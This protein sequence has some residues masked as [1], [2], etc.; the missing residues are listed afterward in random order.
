MIYKINKPNE[1]IRIIGKNFFLRNKN[2]CKII[3]KNEEKNLMEFYESINDE[4]EIKIKIIINNKVVNY[5]YMFSGCNSLISLPDISNLD[6]NN[7]SNISNLFSECSS[8][9]LLDDISKWETDKIYDMSYLFS[10]CSSLKT[11]P[12]ISK[13]NTKNVQNMKFMFSFAS[14]LKNIPNIGNWNINNV[15]N[16]SNMFYGCSSLEQIPNITNWN[17]NNLINISYLFCKCSSLKSLP[18]ISYWNTNKI[19]NMSY[20]FYGCQSLESLPD[21]SKWNTE[22]VEDMSYMFYECS[23]IKNL[24]LITK[25]KTNNVIKLSYMFCGCSSLKS[26]PDISSWNTNKLIDIE[27]IF[28]DCSLLTSFPDISKWKNVKNIDLIFNEYKEKKEETKRKIF[29][30]ELNIFPQI[31][32]TFKSD[33]KIDQNL[34]FKIKEEIKKIIKE[35]NF[36]IIEIK[37]GS[38]IIILT[39][40]FLI[41]SELRKQGNEIDLSQ[42]FNEYVS[43]EVKNLTK[44]LSEHEFVSLGVK[45]RPDI[46]DNNIIDFQSEEKRKEIEAKITRLREEKERQTNNNYNSISEINIIEA[47]NK[48]ELDDIEKFFNDKA[49]EAE[50]QET[51]VKRIIDNLID[52][53]KLFDEEIEKAFQKSVFEYKIIHLLLLDRSDKVKITYLQE[54]NNCPNRVTRILFHGSNVGNIINILNSQIRD[55]GIHIYGKGS[56]FTDV[57]DYACLY[58]MRSEIGKSDIIPEVGHTYSILACE[59][60][61]DKSKLKEGYKYSSEDEVPKNGIKLGFAGYRTQIL[62]QDDLRDYNQFI[63]NEY[64]ITEKSQILPLY[65]IIVERVEYLVVW[66]DYNF[67]ENNPNNY[68]SYTFN[69]MQEFHR[70]IK[71]YVSS[72]L[73]SKIYYSKTTEEAIKLI[74]RKKYNKIV[75]ITN[76][77]NNGEDFINKAREIIGAN[78]IAACS[79]YAVGNHI[80]WVK[81][82]ENVLILNGIDFHKKFFECIKSNDKNLYNKLSKEIISYYSNISDFYLNESTENLFNYVNFKRKCKFEDLVFD[83]D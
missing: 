63:G 45:S 31:E 8:L 66:R 39:L 19:K 35:D 11:L 40:Q 6:L 58:T 49:L 38:I 59:I 78:T 14:L 83:K 74:K 4:K 80:G 33:N 69:K 73:N 2:N 46:V 9:E 55:A 28:N 77:N 16:I 82:M 21:I 25:W 47:S 43:E 12:N 42:I 7:T 20:L 26:I 71:K 36:S 50:Q 75:I 67:N 17:T 37:K 57:L 1:K 61:Y 18:D 34:I 30:D 3:I 81:N 53:N 60:F 68:D 13:W 24:P 54:K 52:F 41:L 62:S 29:N 48:L 23:K 15:S 44:Q 27:G 56:Y 51:N 10:G 64:L 5:S 32:L 22:N 70:Q 72:V 79:A 65:S 76:G